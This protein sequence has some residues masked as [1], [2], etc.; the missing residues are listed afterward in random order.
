[1]SKSLKLLSGYSIPS[2]GLGVYLIPLSETAKI[3]ELALQ[4]G[5]RHFDTARIYGNEEQTGEGIVNFLKKHPEVKRSDIFYTTKVWTNEFGYD[6]TTTALKESFEDVEQLQYID[7]VLLHSPETTKE[8]RLESYRALQDAVDQGF[9]KSIGVSNYGV[10]H[11]KE[12]LSW[13]ELKYKPV[14][15]QIEINPWLQHRDIVS[16]CE[17]EGIVIQAYSPL[18]FGRGKLFDQSLAKLAEKYHKSPAQILIRWNIQKGY[19]PL[20]KTARAE[21]L[22]ENISVYD[23]ELDPKDVEGLGDPSAKCLASPGPDPTEH[24]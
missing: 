17:K 2:I 7:L 13:P 18:L 21:R 11:L 20:P 19:I 4:K 6:R 23:F 1:M 9:V 15:N 22:E 10:H 5:Y 14:V 8:K 12:L 16:F 3:V 24:S